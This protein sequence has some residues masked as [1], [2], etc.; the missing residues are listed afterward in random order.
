MLKATYCSATTMPADDC[1]AQ[2]DHEA[3]AAATA[4]PKIARTA[5]RHGMQ[6]SHQSGSATS[7]YC[8]SVWQFSLRGQ[9]CWSDRGPALDRR[10]A[11]KEQQ[12]GEGLRDGLGDE[13]ER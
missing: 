2:H 1:R 8:L 4:D 9:P 10:G 11:R 7:P 6:E 12:Q 13:T 3:A 5:M